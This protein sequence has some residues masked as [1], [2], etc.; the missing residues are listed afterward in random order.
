MLNGKVVVLSLGIWKE[1]KKQLLPPTHQ[2]RIRSSKEMMM[3]R[4][5]ST[6]LTDLV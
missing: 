3:T 4:N 1:V 2:I 5:C 6:L